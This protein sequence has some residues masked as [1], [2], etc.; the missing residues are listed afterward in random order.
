MAAVDLLQKIMQHH[1][2]LDIALPLGG[3]LHKFRAAMVREVE[4]GKIQ[5]EITSFFQ[6]TPTL[7]FKKNLIDLF[8]VK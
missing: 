5:T 4:T 2:D 7:F 6:Q 1:P 3:Y 8:T